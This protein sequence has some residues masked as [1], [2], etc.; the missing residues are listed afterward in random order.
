VFPFDDEGADI[1]EQRLKIKSFLAGDRIHLAPSCADAFGAAVIERLGFEAIHLSGHAVHKSLCLPDAGLA[2]ASEFEGRI[3]SIVDAVA[4]PLIV[5]G[6]TGFGGIRNMRRT[7]RVLE[8]AG[9][10]AI[11]FEDQVTPRRYGSAA[12]PIISSEEMVSK[13]EAALDERRDPNL[14]IVA[15]CEERSADAALVERLSTYAATGVDALWSSGFSAEIIR[16]V[17]SHARGI[18]FMGIAADLA[19]AA[20]AGVRIAVY[21]TVGIIAAAWGMTTIL[22][23]LRE[24][25]APEDIFRNLAGMEEVR[26]WFREIGKARYA[27]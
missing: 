10:S 12:S 6:E 26:A 5:D 15:R 24:G 27:D 11:H 19:A 8:R 1:R 16:Q 9:A 22:A 21:P 18:P 2:T 14:A 4:L 17:R 3:L 25:N 7:M 23:Q 20:A 13:L